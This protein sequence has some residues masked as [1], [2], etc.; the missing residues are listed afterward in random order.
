MTNKELKAYLKQ[1]ANE[2]EIKDFQTSILERVKML[3]NDSVEV[4][5]K[6]RRIFRLKPLTTS[7]LAVMATFIFVLLLVDQTGINP[8]INEPVLENME[9][10]VALSSIQATSLIEVMEQDLSI[11]NQSLLRMGGPLRDQQIKNEIEDLRRYLDTIEKLYASNE[12]F[13]LTDEEENSSSYLRH[14]RFKARD[15]VNQETMY[16][17]KYNQNINKETNVYNVTG[18]V[19]VGSKSYLMTAQGIKGQKQIQLTVTNEND[20]MVVLDYEEIEGIHHYT[21]ELI[22]HDETLEIVTISLEKK[23]EKKIA[24]LSFIEGTSTGIYVFEIIEEDFKKVIQITYTLDF[25]GDIE[26]GII[27]IRILSLPNANM[28]SI[29]V[30][31]EGRQGFSITQGRRTPNNNPNTQSHI[32]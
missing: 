3:Q 11:S 21:V 1:K 27:T 10:V 23:G 17:L 26:Q 15:L 2:V 14:M 13:D 25:S 19:V 7:L 5:E 28:Y 16:E 20:F 9:N 32:F 24:T 8:V 30:K 18:E 29:Q 12:D 22:N 6:P 31:P 4:I